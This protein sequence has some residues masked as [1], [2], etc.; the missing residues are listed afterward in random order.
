MTLNSDVGGDVIVFGGQVHISGTIKGDLITYGGTV[1]M[2]AAVSGKARIGGGDIHINGSI[3]ENT[4]VQAENVALGSGAVLAGDF[5]YS[6]VKEVVKENGAQV[7]GKETFTPNPD[8]RKAAKQGVIAFLSL[9]FFLKFLML[10]AGALVIGLFFRKYATELGLRSLAEPVPQAVTGIVTLIVLPV[11]SGI[12]MVSVIGLPLGI[13]G[14]L[15]WAALV[16]T[17]HLV[18]PIVLGSLLFAW[19]LHKPIEVNWKTILVGSFVFYFIGFIPFVGW[20]A[21]TFFLILTVGAML[22]MKWRIAKEWR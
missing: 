19:I 2:D 8:F 11:I 13:L 10:T 12:L 3:A 16:M 4:Q 6:A 22:R 5:E 20:L 17:G 18:A 1:L 7:V 15:S 9:W 14:M 21:R